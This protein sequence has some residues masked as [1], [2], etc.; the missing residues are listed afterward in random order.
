M[1]AEWRHKIL[2][3]TL[4]VGDQ[5]LQGADCPPKQY[6]PP[7]GFCVSIAVKDLPWMINC[8]QLSQI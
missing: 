6:Q 2:H 1:P 3:A 4:K 5:F 7:R 8:A